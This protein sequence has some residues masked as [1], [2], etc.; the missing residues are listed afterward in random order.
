MVV[1]MCFLRLKSDFPHFLLPISICKVSLFFFSDHQLQLISINMYCAVQWSSFCALLPPSDYNSVEN[2]CHIMRYLLY[3]CKAMTCAVL[4]DRNGPIKY[5]VTS[6][7]PA[8]KLLLKWKNNPGDCK[9]KVQ[10][11]TEYNTIQYNTMV[12]C[13]MTW[14]K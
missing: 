7:S 5:S 4:T 2:T 13:V 9:S 6:K 3:L 12:H 11:R 8:L 10:N 14:S 1:W